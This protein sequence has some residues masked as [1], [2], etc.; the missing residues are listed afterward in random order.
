LLKKLNPNIEVPE[1]KII[2]VKKAAI[3]LP[4]YDHLREGVEVIDIPEPAPKL[5]QYGD[6]S[7]FLYHFTPLVPRVIKKKKR[8]EEVKLFDFVDS[9]KAIQGSS[10]EDDECKLS[11]RKKTKPQAAQ[12]AAVD[13]EQI[14]QEARKSDDDEGMLDDLEDESPKKKKRRGTK[15]TRKQESE[16]EIP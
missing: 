6:G 11:R 13:E 14:K 5:P 7:D 9:S 16:G 10:G 1:P 3:K 8:N 12:D 15:K 2:E 4:I